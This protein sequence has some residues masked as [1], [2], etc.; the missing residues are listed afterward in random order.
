MKLLSNPSNII[1]SLLTFIC[2]DLMIEWLWDV[3]EKLS[4]AAYAVAL[5]TFLLIQILGIECGIFAGVGFHFFLA[6]LGFDV[7]EV[8]VT[9]HESDTRE[10]SAF[11]A[12][13]NSN[14]LSLHLEN[15][16]GTLVDENTFLLEKYQDAV[17]SSPILT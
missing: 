12:D 2:V 9:E 7:A 10:E 16:N 14:D 3:R 8:S 5:T 15:D 17:Y 11:F 1:A 4:P 13:S 6:K